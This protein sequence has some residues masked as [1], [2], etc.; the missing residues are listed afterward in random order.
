MESDIADC[1]AL[2]EVREEDEINQRVKMAACDNLYGTKKQWKELYKFLKE[3]KSDWIVSMKPEP[4]VDDVVTRICYTADIQGW[5]YENCSLEWV[6]NQL[7]SNF[8]VQRVILGKAHHE[9]NHN[10]EDS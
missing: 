3:S 6:K 4:D 5:L 7:E 9:N 8:D 10:Y 2:K 1:V